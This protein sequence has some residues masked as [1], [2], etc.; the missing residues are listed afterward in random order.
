MLVRSL[1]LRFVRSTTFAR[2]GCIFRR[3]PIDHENFADVLY[4]RCVEFFT[5]LQEQGIAG[6]PAGFARSNLDQFVRIKTGVNFA[7]YSRGQ[8]IVANEDNGI[9]RMCAGT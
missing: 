4:R 1:G 3:G 6:F 9:E 7:K 8:A 5:D 2:R